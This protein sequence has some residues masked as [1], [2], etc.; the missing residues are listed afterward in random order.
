MRI[1]VSSSY[2]D[3]QEHRAAAIRVLRQLGHEV[4]AMEDMVAGSSP[5]LAKVLEM[6]DRAE[7]YVGL[8]AWRYGYVP[9]PPLAAKVAGAHPGRTSITHFEYL[10]AKERGIP[11]L[12]F[13]LDENEPWA[14]S[15]VDGFDPGVHEDA[16]ATGNQSIRTLR[17][18]LQ[19]EKVISWFT[20]P[21]SLEARVAAA[22]TMAGLSR[23]IDLQPAVQVAYGGGF[24]A[25]DDSGGN[26]IAIAVGQAVMSQRIFKIDLAHPWWST[27]LY[28]LAALAERLTQVRRI[29]VVQTQ[30]GGAAGDGVAF[31][32]QLG[33]A[34][35]IATLRPR[36][37]QFAVFERLLARRPAVAGDATAAEEIMRDCWAP[38]FRG[39]G[40][41]ANTAQQGEEA[42]KIDLSADLLQR[43][44]GDSMLQQPVE[45]ADLKRVSVVDLLRLVDYPSPFVPVLSGRAP[46]SAEPLG[47]VDVLDKTALNA[48][49]AHSYL[50]E[51]KERARIV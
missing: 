42:A 16:D 25:V 26:S 32:G 46:G 39:A 4:L 36:L 2:T 20:T 8:F 5:P 23:Q 22:V 44:F 38:A 12:A 7:A 13:L 33:T 40:T 18:E 27:R 49:L 1:F 10:H 47:Q 28:L 17:R 9:Q 31:V 35:V 45:I 43:W 37:R 29:L 41:G 34:T 19:Q 6:V 48:R 30:P 51:L 50:T 24:G 3:L 15:L 11:I 14:P 21:A